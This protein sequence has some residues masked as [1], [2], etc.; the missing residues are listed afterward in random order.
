MKGKSGA[1]QTRIFSS[2][3]FCS[4]SCK[5]FKEVELVSDEHLF[6]IFV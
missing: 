6:L 5:M 2:S 1:S 4:Y 3:K